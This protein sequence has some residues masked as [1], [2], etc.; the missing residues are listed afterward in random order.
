MLQRLLFY[1]IL[2]LQKTLLTFLSIAVAM[3]IGVVRSPSVVY[4]AEAAFVIGSAS[5][6][7]LKGPQR[8]SEQNYY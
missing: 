3:Y 7:G 2:Y 4:K 6:S 1:I 5:S 8:P